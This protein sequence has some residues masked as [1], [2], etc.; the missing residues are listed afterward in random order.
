MKIK[1]TRQIGRKLARAAQKVFNRD[2]V[3]GSIK[4]KKPYGKWMFV[5][6]EDG[7]VLWYETECV[8]HNA[9]VC[10]GKLFAQ[11]TICMDA[12]EECVVVASGLAPSPDTT[13]AFDRLTYDFPPQKQ[14]GTQLSLS[15]TIV[16]QSPA[17]PDF[18]GGDNPLA[19]A[20][21]GLPYNGVQWGVGVSQFR[22]ESGALYMPKLVG[23]Q[24]ADCTQ[25]EE[26]LRFVSS[27]TQDIFE[28]SLCLDETP[29]L[30]HNQKNWDGTFCKLVGV[31]GF[32]GTDA[33]CR[34]LESYQI[35]GASVDYLQVCH[36][37]K[38]VN[39][40]PVSLFG[41]YANAGA[42]KVY[43]DPTSRFVVMV[44]NTFLTVFAMDTIPK[45]LFRTSAAKVRTVS[46]C[47]NGAF[48]VY[49]GDTL[50]LFVPD[51]DSVYKSVVTNTQGIDNV[52]LLPYDTEYYGLAMTVGRDTL[53]CK[54]STQQGTVTL[55][56]TLLDCNRIF[57]YDDE[58]LF[59]DS[60]DGAEWHLFYYDYDCS[61][62][63]DKVRAAVATRTV[64]AGD[65]GLYLYDNGRQFNT[66]QNSA[67]RPTGFGQVGQ[68][69]YLQNNL[70]IVVTNSFT[71]QVYWFDR[72]QEQFVL[73]G[74]LAL[75]SRPYTA[76]VAQGYL[77]FVLNSGVLLCFRHDNG[78]TLLTFDGASTQTITINTS[79][80]QPQ[81]TGQNTV[82]IGLQ[83]Q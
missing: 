44:S 82:T 51:A 18:V 13:L 59:V 21:L 41:E 74:T 7:R 70:C 40:N 46:V 53:L 35:S 78:S 71:A 58:R 48:V 28:T 60:V 1:S 37:G 5:E 29:V 50:T 30:R 79:Q 45:M 39:P 19:R 80:R 26:G 20:C 52:I 65:Y 66:V 81:A 55:Q 72:Q 57:M 33:E 64:L 56:N 47:A 38:S 75:P 11:Y 68:D 27:T 77:V 17:S 63:A 24:K 8:E 32:F 4:D 6:C 15:V 25:T 3:F 23:V 36:Y 49:D 61:T 62:Q 10:K 14:R 43:K 2:A 69:V 16:L 12:S 34:Y 31:N 73:M 42:S 9:D 83:I 67:L 22:Q 54:M 76:F